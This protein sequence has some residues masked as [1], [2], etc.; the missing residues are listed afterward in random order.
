MTLTSLNEGTPV[1]SIEA[2]AAGLPI[3]TTDVGG[4]RDI[5]IENE[6]ALISESNNLEE[7]SN[8]LINCIENKKLRLYLSKRKR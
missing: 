7:F 2:Q 5:V 1:S 3:V 4:I 6:T 8:K